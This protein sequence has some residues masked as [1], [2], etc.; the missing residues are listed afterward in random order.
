MSHTPETRVGR[1]LGVFSPQEIFF[2]YAGGVRLTFWEAEMDCYNAKS[3]FCTGI[4][5]ERP[6]DP[7]RPGKH[8]TK[9]PAPLSSFM[10]SIHRQQLAR[11]SGAACMQGFASTSYP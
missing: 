6:L 7:P 5:K 10:D 8:S 11:A 1:V 4:S 2:R 9:T 3:H